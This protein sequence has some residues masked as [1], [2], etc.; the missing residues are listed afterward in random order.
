MAGAGAAVIGLLI[1][2]F[3]DPVWVSAVGGALDVV[4]AV[5]AFAALVLA[6]TPPYLVVLL[7]AAAGE[8]AVR[9]PT[10]VM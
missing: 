5:A 2:A 9:V 4:L 6:R 8:I 10:L 3:Y 7:L 1:A